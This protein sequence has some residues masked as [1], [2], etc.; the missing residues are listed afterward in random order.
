M[1][2]H[3]EPGRFMLRVA[4][5]AVRDA[6]TRCAARR[7]DWA[8]RCWPR[9]ALG[10]RPG[11]AL[12]DPIGCTACPATRTSEDRRAPA[13]AAPPGLQQP[14]ARR[15]PAP[16]RAGRHARRPDRRRAARL[17]R[18][19]GAWQSCA[20]RAGSCSLGEELAGRPRRAARAGAED[21]LRHGLLL[22]S[23]TLDAAARRLCIAR[24]AHAGQAQPQ[25]RS[26]RC[27]PTSTAPPARPARSAPSP[28]S[29]SAVR[30]ER[31]VRPRRVGG[32]LDRP[33]AAQRRRARPASPS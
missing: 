5:A 33:P 8:G 19:R 1:T 4:G 16:R 6:W 9:R 13:D 7:C 18:D 32:D 14:A 15:R 3:L 27:C 20:R 25:D 24:P 12:S 30:A 28:G 22:A 10:P 23:P 21:R 31:R 2:S 17:A 11:A 26:A 29:R